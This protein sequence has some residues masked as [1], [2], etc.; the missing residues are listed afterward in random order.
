MNQMKIIQDYSSAW[1]EHFVSKLTLLIIILR[2]FV[3]Q[4]ILFCSYLQTNV[5][6]TVNGNNIQ[7][8]YEISFTMLA[9]LKSLES[10][11]T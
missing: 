8:T 1:G 5:N 4:K 7:F 6:V 3:F 9:K 2:P 11:F 10:A